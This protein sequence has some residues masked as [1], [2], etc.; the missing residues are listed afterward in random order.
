M[1][2]IFLLHLTA[3]LICHSKIRIINVLI[4]V[5]ASSILY[6]LDYVVYKLLK[7]EFLLDFFVKS[8]GNNNMDGYYY[9]IMP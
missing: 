9:I 8:D 7:L 2:S 4:W 5:G 1:V 3:S 6:S